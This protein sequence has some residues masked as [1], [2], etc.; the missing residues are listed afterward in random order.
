[1]NFPKYWIGTLERALVLYRV[2]AEAPPLIAT[3][4]ARLSRRL[5]SRLTANST[6]PP[7]KRA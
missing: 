7:F 3:V 4:V 2:L 1:M 6:D 5:G